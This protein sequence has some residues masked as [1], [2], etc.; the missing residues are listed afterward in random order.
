MFKNIFVI[1]LN[2]KNSNNKKIKN[3]Q[4]NVYFNKKK[5]AFRF[6]YFCLIKQLKLNKK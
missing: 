4:W 1:Y 5:N 2:K 6:Y 3:I